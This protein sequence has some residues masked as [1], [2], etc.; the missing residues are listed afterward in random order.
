MFTSPSTTEENSLTEALVE[1]S[2]DSSTSGC[3][4]T[5]K[6]VK[7]DKTTP[8]ASTRNEAPEMVACTIDLKEKIP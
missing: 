5:K 8:D 3:K 6:L 1:G 7:R 4:L 2:E